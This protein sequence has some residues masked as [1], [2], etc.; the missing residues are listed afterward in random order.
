[1]R[2]RDKA[3][4]AIVA[5]CIGLTVYEIPNARLIR[6]HIRMINRDN[7]TP[8]GKQGVKSRLTDE[9]LAADAEAADILLYC[10]SDPSD[11][12]LADLVAKYPDNEF[13]LALLADR[14]A[15]AGLVDP[16]AA[17]ALADGARVT[18]TTS[19]ILVIPSNTFCR[20]C[21]SR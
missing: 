10:L 13:F 20:A 6:R 4:L 16:R 11:E 5:V 18:R 2:L 8:Q 14:L 12:D 1:M 9:L 7:D 3:W 19:G 15:D 17:L 21:F